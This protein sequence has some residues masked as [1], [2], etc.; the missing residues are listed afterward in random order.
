MVPSDRSGIPLSEDLHYSDE[1]E[2]GG[3]VSHGDEMS[4]DDKDA[5]PLLD[6][7]EA[8][9][10][11]LRNEIEKDLRTLNIKTVYDSMLIYHQ[12][13]SYPLHCISLDLCFIIGIGLTE[14]NIA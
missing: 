8:S 6:S 11:R 2:N 9:L 14:C 13:Y 10:E 1:E 5:A 12:A 7:P 3:P 4:D